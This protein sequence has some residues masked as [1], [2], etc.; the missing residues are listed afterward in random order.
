MSHIKAYCPHCGEPIP[1]HG[2]WKKPE[3]LTEAI[4][5]PNIELFE[6]LTLSNGY[7]NKGSVF[8][9]YDVSQIDGWIPA[10]M[11]MDA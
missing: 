5:D 9:G 1:Y 4:E 3:S 2:P 11:G 7:V 10:P 6:I 8:S